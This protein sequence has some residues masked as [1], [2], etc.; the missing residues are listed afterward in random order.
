MIFDLHILK[1]IT[2]ADK[3]APYEDLRDRALPSDTL[4]QHIFDLVPLIAHQIY[5]KGLERHDHLC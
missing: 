3:L 2:T 5:V 4:L 1:G